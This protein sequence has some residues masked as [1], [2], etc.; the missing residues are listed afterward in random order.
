MGKNILFAM[1]IGLLTAVLFFLLWSLFFDPL[2]QNE[3]LPTIASP[4]DLENQ[5]YEQIGTVLPQDTAVPQPTATPEPL[6]YTIQAGDTL[7]SIAR[8]HNITL[9]E[10]TAANGI[11]NPNLIEVGQVLVIPNVVTEV[12]VAGETAVQQEVVAEVVADGTVVRQTTMNGVPID[13]LIIMP[14]NVVKNAQNIYVQGQALGNNP[15]AFSKIG[16]STIQIPFFLARFD[17]P[18]GYNLGDYAY[19]QPTI[20]F[21]AGSFGREGMAV[22]KGFHSWTVTDPAWADKSVCQPNETPIACEIRVQ[23]PSII[24]IR[25][26]SNDAGVPDMFDKNIRQIVEFSI[27][28]GVIPVIG[29]KADRAEGSNVNNDVLRRIAA[30]YEI[31]LWEFDIAAGT[32]PGRGLDVDN[33]HLNTFYA[34]DYTSPTAFQKGHSVHNLTAL[35][36]L[37]ALMNKVILASGG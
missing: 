21:F 31:P 24:F 26:G 20:D 32:L 12:V 15:Q 23:R 6:T 7:F 22:R 17:Q 28:N 14:E 10:L 5:A 30:D 13:G 2:N 16:D 37:D 29:T 3:V 18:G 1:G 4:A 19:L 35:M 9:I 25:L 8:T 36:M 33:V 34:H 11:V 27:V